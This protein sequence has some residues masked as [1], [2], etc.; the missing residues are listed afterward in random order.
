MSMMHLALR[1]T[2]CSKM[3]QMMNDSPLSY[4]PV[5]KHFAASACFLH[6][7]FQTEISQKKSTDS[8]SVLSLSQTVRPPAPAVAV[9]PAAG[10]RR[11]PC[12]CPSSPTSQTSTPPSRPG[13]REKERG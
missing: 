9:V 7:K 5:S 6:L 10:R 1:S 3:I 13:D 8:M 2:S 11:P 12:T 4:L